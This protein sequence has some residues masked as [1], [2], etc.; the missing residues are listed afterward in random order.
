LRLRDKEVTEGAMGG[1]PE[2]FNVRKILEQKDKEIK[3]VRSE[4][5][6]SQGEVSS[7]KR[8]LEVKDR[9]IEDAKKSMKRAASGDKDDKTDE[10][11][12]LQI[13]LLDLKTTRV[14]LL[15]KLDD[16]EHE[17]EMLK[18]EVKLLKGLPN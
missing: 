13:M 1:S 15:E 12:R 5:R 2:S 11:A 9:E 17:S 18:K 14:D 8:K 10:I 3:S 7:L 6:S 4:L 16:A